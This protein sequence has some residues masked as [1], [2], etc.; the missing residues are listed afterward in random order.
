MAKN[1][2]CFRSNTYAKKK[3]YSPISY[4]SD[5]HSQTHKKCV[6]YNIINHIGTR[7]NKGAEIYSARKSLYVWN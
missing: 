5:S 7:K 3:L 2:I 4:Q 1:I 6:V